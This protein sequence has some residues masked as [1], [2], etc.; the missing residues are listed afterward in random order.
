M[1]K[2]L[3][4]K[5]QLRININPKEDIGPE[6]IFSD[7]V[8]PL[9]DE[10]N[11]KKL[12][13]SVDS[14]RFKIFFVCTFILFFVFTAYVVY[15]NI[16][17]GQEYKKLSQK[18]ANE[19]YE[20][21]PSRGEIKTKD[22]ISIASADTAY[23]LLANPV[24]LTDEQILEISDYIFLNFNEDV[25]DK[26][27]SYKKQHLGN[28]ILL[29]NLSEYH[30]DELN[31][32]L[33]KYNLLTLREKSI[34]YYP[35]NNLF[36]HI[37]GYTANIGKEDL[38]KLH[39]YEISDDIGKKGVEYYFEKYLKGVSGIFAKFI[40]ST[41][42]I[43]K[44]GL[45]REIE[46]GNEVQLTIDY[47]LQ[48][49]TYGAIEKSLK[50]NNL[51]SGAVVVMD[52]KT[53]GILALV[54]MP[55][56][57]PNYFV[58]GL[59]DEQ[60]S[61]YFNNKNKPLFNRV[62]AGEYAT[63]SLIKPLIAI[64]AL[65]E[66]IID[67]KK[68]I[69]T[70]GYIEVPSIYDSNVVYRFD[71]W[72]NHGAVDMVD[73]IA[74]S[75][76]VYFYTI[77]GGYGDQEGLGAERIAKYLRLFNWGSTLGI[78]FAVEG[79][80]LVPT[81]D[82]KLKTKEENWT[83]GDTYNISIG[84]GDILATPLQVATAT[85]VFAS[86]GKLFKPFIVEKIYSQDGGL[87][88]EFHSD[89]IK[90]SFLSLENLNIVKNGMRQAVVSGSSRFLFNLPFEVAGK[91]GTAQTSGIANNAWF[92]GYGPYS[93]PQIVVTVLLEAGESSDKAVRVAYDIFQ[94]YFEAH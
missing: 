61:L 18:N 56:F 90:E 6:D 41:G 92:S 57:N 3:F 25:R 30:A 69:I 74:V 75:S 50:Q 24:E 23:D 42:E 78:N 4:K 72:K 80:G 21:G 63:G 27:I 26:L 13:V 12:Q 44:E 94:A 36:S 60:A 76:N 49:A 37:L 86:N 2:K 40:T 66:G 70:R 20:V 34:R 22:G 17:H 81:S 33:N 84:Q 29:K 5:N 48:K 62:V 93:D 68:N 10:I 8:S 35:D 11:E 59:T 67:P 19:A 14:M 15:I 39:E 31:I 7:V 89:I 16:L 64:A 1:I 88:A 54:S 28:L 55:D 91:T 47:G 77:G 52:V 83:I 79:S 46:K 53:G 38:E 51:T 43:V 82:W 45:V 9:Y 85:A 32:L 73:A 71:D 58:R 87:V 65:Q